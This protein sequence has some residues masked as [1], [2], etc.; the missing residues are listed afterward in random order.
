MK[1]QVSKCIGSRLRGLSR[2]VDNI[3]RKHLEGSNITEHQ[4]SIMLALSEVGRAEQIEIGRV[5]HLERS[6]L[7]RNLNRLVD[8]K[9]IKKEGA[10]NR[11]I[12]SLTKKGINKVEDLLPAWESAMDEIYRL[13]GAKAISSFDNFEKSFK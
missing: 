7:S 13:L 5:L 9:Y 1:Y 3:Y 6:S 4:L 11:P 8:K 12:I 2:V 10:V